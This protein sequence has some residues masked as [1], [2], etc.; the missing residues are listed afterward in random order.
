MAQQLP[1]DVH[2]I[3]AV[4][5]APPDGLRPLGELADARSD[6]EHEQAKARLVAL[7]DVPVA[8]G[9]VLATIVDR[10]GIVSP[11]RYQHEHGWPYGSYEQRDALVRQLLADARQAAS[12]P[13]RRAAARAAVL[14]AAQEGFLFGATWLLRLTREKD[15]D[16]LVPWTAAQM[17]R[18]RERLDEERG[19]TSRH[20]A[21]FRVAT[22]TLKMLIEQPA[23]GLDPRLVDDFVAAMGRMLEEA[24]N[25]PE[26]QW[27]VA[28]HA[29]LLVNLA[30]AR[31]Q[32]PVIEQVRAAAGQWRAATPT[33]EFG[34]WLDAA[35]T[36]PWPAA[37][38]N[39]VA[40]VSSDDVNAR[41]IRT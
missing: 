10:V 27:R 20:L 1:F 18:L 32:Q 15:I 41:L 19:Q 38:T 17:R 25:R 37:Q 9:Q 6:Q 29:W 7:L 26:F 12:E 40:F 39:G 34:R 8:P 30:A 22:S 33:P 4:P 13:Q 3:L 14:L 11:R 23:P 35:F 16:Q 5:P 31:E 2:E 24:E 36:T 28:N 21:H